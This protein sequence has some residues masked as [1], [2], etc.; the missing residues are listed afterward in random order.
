MV[1]LAYKYLYKEVSVT[2]N[3]RSSWLILSRGTIIKNDR[4]LWLTHNLIHILKIKY[5]II[6]NKVSACICLNCKNINVINMTWSFYARKTIKTYELEF[7]GDSSK[8]PNVW[9]G[10]DQGGCSGSGSECGWFYCVLI[11]PL[12]YGLRCYRSPL[13]YL[14]SA[15]YN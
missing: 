7:T 6:T 1:F 11:P 2:G 3:M 8:S 10:V 9:R 12:I 14:L 5:Y 4:N 13:V 15:R